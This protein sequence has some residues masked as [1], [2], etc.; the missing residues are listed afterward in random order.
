MKQKYGIWGLGLVGKSALNYLLHDS[1][2]NYNYQLEVLENRTL[3]SN[4]LEFLVNNNVTYKNQTDITEFLE[5]NDFIIPSPGINL[6]NFQKYKSKIISEL[7]IFYQSWTK[8]NKKII[9]IT[10]T[11]GKTT[12][13][14]LL[15]KILTNYNFKVVLGGNIGIPMLDLL[16]DKEKFNNNDL[17][18]LELSSFQLDICKNFNSDLAIWTN[19]YPNHIDM[20]K[21]IDN[22]FNAKF[23]IIKNQSTNQKALVPL[24][25]IKKIRKQKEIQSQLIFFRKKEPSPSKLDLIQNQEIVYFIK[26]KQIIKLTKSQDKFIKTKILDISKIECLP[27]SKLSYLEN[28]LIIIAACDILNIDIKKL[29][30]IKGLEVPEHRM[31][32]V[33]NYKNITFYNDS[34]STIPE[35]TLAAINQLENQPIILFLGGLSKGVDRT[36]LIKKLKNKVKLI[37]CFGA[38][39]KQL[40]QL[41]ELNKIKSYCYNNLEDAF[42]GLTYLIDFN[43]ISNGDNVVFSPS[44]S[45]FDLFKDY[46][47]RGNQF[48]RLVH[49]LINANLI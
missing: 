39:A 14:T 18:L 35:A 29:K 4:E 13:T 43:D 1:S 17:A 16:T 34:K 7:D 22:Y 27:I 20:H 11:L 42:K 23:N 38:E 33:A 36:N 2:I 19:F 31:E 44:G 8:Q 47:D 46:Q 48:K 12:V 37:I 41:C 32:F 21:S 40:H 24:N 25:L 9:S 3:Q 6:S 45:S 30:L 49:T 28:W 5:K 15:N 26:N 10:G